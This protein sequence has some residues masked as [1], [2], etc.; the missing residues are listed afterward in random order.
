MFKIARVSKHFWEEPIISGTCGSGTIF[1]S[2]CTM[3]CA[4]CQNYK[5]SQEGKGIEISDNQLVSLM[6][7]LQESG[8]HNINLVTPSLYTK[9]LAEA[10]YDAKMNGLTIPVVYNTSSFERWE[11]LRVLD[12]LVDIYL[13]DLKYFDNAVA[14]K[15]S[16]IPN[17]FE[18]ASSAIAEMRRQ[19][20]N[21][22]FDGDFIMKKGVLARHLV[23]PSQ[24]EDSKK[25]LDFLK[26]LDENIYVS[27][28]SQYFPPR[29][30]EYDELNRRL[31]QKEYDE[32]FHHFQKIGLHNGF[33]Q[34]VESAI[35]DYV[36][37]FDLNELKQLLEG[38]K[39][40]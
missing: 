26:S 38:L 33:I 19:Q 16:G 32:V 15:Y 35:E 24:T 36:P 31:T 39:H 12:G 20:P 10:I 7:H 22:I 29:Q 3:R 27:L 8:V 1:F 18:V 4:Y 13:P 14:K 34:D 11:T 9:R 5:I 28:M 21:D 30:L 25:V 37:S 2:G 17:Y 23:L 6:L 40:K